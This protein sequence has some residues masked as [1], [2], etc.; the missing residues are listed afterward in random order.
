MIKSIRCEST[1][2]ERQIE[3]PPVIK[4]TESDMCSAKPRPL[5]EILWVMINDIDGEWPGELFGRIDAEDDLGSQVIY[6]VAKSSFQ[7]VRPRDMIALRTSRPLAASGDFVID[8]DLW[9]RDRDFS[10]ND[11]VS[12]GKISWKAHDSNNDYDFPIQKNISGEYGEATVN[13]VVMSSATQAVVQ[14]IMLDGD[15]EEPADVY[16][17]VRVSSLFVQRDL[18]NRESGDSIEIYPDTY[19]PLSRATMAVPMLDTLQIHVNLWD[20]DGPW[21]PDDEIAY[22]LEEFTPQV[23]GAESRVVTGEYGEVK[24]SVTWGVDKPQGC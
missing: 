18:F 17:R 10:A 9:D 5:A 14:I 11:Q 6:N 22:G 13:Y 20:R 7:S 2:P 16:G 1:R 24:V 23:S 3:R 4:I 21:S 19:I 15:K 12:K 8:L